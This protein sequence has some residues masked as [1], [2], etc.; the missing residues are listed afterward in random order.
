MNHIY[1]KTRIFRSP[2]SR[3]IKT[4][5]FKIELSSIELNELTIEQIQKLA[6]NQKQVPFSPQTG[7][8]NQYV[9]QFLHLASEKQAGQYKQGKLNSTQII[10][11]VAH[12]FQ[13]GER[14]IGMASV[15]GLLHSRNIS[16]DLVR[17]I[18]CSINA[19]SLSPISEQELGSIVGSVAKYDVNPLYI[20]PVTDDILTFGDASKRWYEIRRK[21]NKID[22]GFEHLNKTIPFFDPGQVM[23]IAA[24]PGI[25]KTCIGMQLANN[26]A[27]GLNELGLMISL[28]MPAP[29]LFARA[30][31]IEKHRGLLET[32]TFEEVTDE[33][34]SSND[35]KAKTLDAWKHVVVVDKTDLPIDKIEKYYYLTIDKFN[36]QVSNLFIDYGGLIQGADDYQT[37]SKIARDL[38]ALSKRLNTR[39]MLCVQLSRKAGDGTI[40][41]TY[42]MLRDS[43]EW[44]AAADYIVGMW[45]SKTDP[46]RIHAVKCKD[47]FNGDRNFFFDIIN[48]GLCYKTEGYKEETERQLF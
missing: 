6:A 42:D 11:G 22:L 30:A 39:V 18:L 41:V 17:A 14:N 3:N 26:I 15:A 33:L 37:I 1:D 44:E 12:G 19:A 13:E 48:H 38:K 35:L 29:S 2:N 16:D 43:G 31:T 28:E 32:K 7:E 8:Y 10:E 23:I 36:I 9:R 45:L 4:G 47:R 40:P 46:N 24:R 5:L 27:K 20:D 25:G 34:L 21:L